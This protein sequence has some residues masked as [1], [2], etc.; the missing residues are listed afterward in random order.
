MRILVT[1]ATGYIG[2]ALARELSAAG[3]EVVGRA[4]SYAAAAT[5]RARGIAVQQRDLA[6]PASLSA[7]AAEADG[8]VHTAFVNPSPTTD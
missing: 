1:G 6:D 7:A 8:V 4:R 2:S 3:H 5:L